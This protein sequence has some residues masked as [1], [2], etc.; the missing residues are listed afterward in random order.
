M[1][2]GVQESE[3][4]VSNI[5][6]RPTYWASFSGGK[7][8]LF[9]IRYILENL[10]KYPLD[11]VV[12]FE[13]SIDFPFIKNVVNYVEDELGRFGIPMMRI[14][15]RI[16]WE[17]LYARYGYPTRKSRWCNKWKL[18]AKKQLNEMMIA[19]GKRVIHYIGFCADEERRFV[20]QLNDRRP[21][22]T[23]IYPLAE[24][25]IEEATILEWAKD[26]PIFNGYYNSNKRCGCM[27]CP[28]AS[29]DNLVYAK[30]NYPEQ[31]DHFMHLAQ[32]TEEKLG[33]QLGRAFSVWSSNAKYNTAYKMRRVDQIIEERDRQMKFEWLDLGNYIESEG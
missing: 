8:S 25:G 2:L 27:C 30:S 7:D 4:K 14:K 6:L 11:G 10:D 31:Y 18:D 16:S 29:L 5:E 15:P 28:M 32:M 12:H 26:V 22:V 21:N 19:Q 13:L 20:S 17:E 9:M 33:E 1:D 23:Q 3:Q 24:A